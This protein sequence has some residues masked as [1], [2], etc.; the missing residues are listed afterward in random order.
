MNLMKILTQTINVTKPS[1]ELETI[2]FEHKIDI[3]QINELKIHSKISYGLKITLIITTTIVF[4]DVR[5]S[6]NV[7][8]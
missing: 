1:V 7:E 8:V 4:I 2:V 3:N 5:C 6:K